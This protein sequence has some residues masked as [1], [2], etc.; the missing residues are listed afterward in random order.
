MAP[1]SD[2]L[3]SVSM[4]AFNNDTD[5]MRCRRATNA[6]HAASSHAFRGENAEGRGSEESGFRGT[7]DDF[8]LFLFTLFTILSYHIRAITS[9]LHTPWVRRPTSARVI[10]PAIFMIRKM[11]SESADLILQ[12]SRQFSL[13]WRHLRNAYLS[14]NVHDETARGSRPLLHLFPPLLL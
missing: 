8:F 2:T 9:H 1:R 14:R 3:M 4:T 10:S 11:F 12:G 5:S 6:V 7:S 13:R